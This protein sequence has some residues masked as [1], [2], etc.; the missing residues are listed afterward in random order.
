[1]QNVII[2]LLHNNPSASVVPRDDRELKLKYTHTKE[3]STADIPL[4]RDRECLF[5]KTYTR[6]SLDCGF[7]FCVHECI[8]FKYQILLVII[9]LL[10]PVIAW[11]CLFY[12]CQHNHWKWYDGCAQVSR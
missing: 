6:I 12:F 1:M 8:K 3:I 11:V 7:W 10:L 2:F 4:A 9:L 5:F